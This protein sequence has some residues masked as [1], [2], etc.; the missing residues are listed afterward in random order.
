MRQQSSFCYLSPFF[1]FFLLEKID[2]NYSNP[3]K[4]FHFIFKEKK[5]Q[6][7]N[8]RK[9]SKNNSSQKSSCSIFQN[10]QNRAETGDGKKYGN[11]L[12]KINENLEL[13][14]PS[15]PLPSSL[16]P[17]S[18]SPSPFPL[19]SLFP[20]LP[21]SPGVSLEQKIGYSIKINLANFLK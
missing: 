4:K 10:P 8:R 14:A 19:P 2:E 12:K 15:P 9:I 17:S 7:K 18:F 1:K 20:S 11:N 6:W 21:L 16:S 3:R 13:I 5:V